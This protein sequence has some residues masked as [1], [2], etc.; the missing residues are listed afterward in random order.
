MRNKNKNNKKEE[1]VK[2]ENNEEKDSTFFIKI[3][4][5]NK[6]INDLLAKE[7]SEIIDIYAEYLG[8]DEKNGE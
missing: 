5:N 1:E 8:N 4:K 3:D 7:I 6:D 2:I